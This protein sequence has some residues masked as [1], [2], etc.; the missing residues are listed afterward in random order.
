MVG[1]E[2]VEY[3]SENNVLTKGAGET[4]PLKQKG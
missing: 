1:E 2:V 3:N 4:V